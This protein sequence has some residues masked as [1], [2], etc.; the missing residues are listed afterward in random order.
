MVGRMYIASSDPQFDWQR[1]VCFL[2]ARATAAHTVRVIQSADS[3]VEVKRE[4]AASAAAA[5]AAVDNG[6]DTLAALVADDD[7][8]QVIFQGLQAKTR[9]TLDAVAA[10]EQH[11]ETER[12]LPRSSELWTCT[13]TDCGESFT[14]EHRLRRHEHI[15]HGKPGRVTCA[16]MFCSLDFAD[17]AEMEAHMVEAHG[18]ERRS[19]G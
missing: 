14:R 16:A 3:D 4:A 7:R 13:V 5:V 8:L 15:V 11:L 18:R 17:T 6:A 9:A 19:H 10:L 1:D 2:D 12:L